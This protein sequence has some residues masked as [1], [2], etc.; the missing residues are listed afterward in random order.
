MI[1]QS[2]GPCLALEKPCRFSY[3]LSIGVR[4]SLSASNLDSNLSMELHIICEIDFA[5]IPAAYQV[6][7]SIAT[8]L[9]AFE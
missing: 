1:E 3:G 4:R 7:E 5:H 9:L 8:E 2:N 6:Q